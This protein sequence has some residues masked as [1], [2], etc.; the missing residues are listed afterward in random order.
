MLLSR[1]TAK[2]AAHLRSA[3]DL[4]DPRLIAAVAVAGQQTAGLAVTASAAAAN[5]GSRKPNARRGK[6]GGPRNNISEQQK[7]HGKSQPVNK[8]SRLAASFK[9]RRCPPQCCR[10]R[11]RCRATVKP[12]RPPCLQRRVL[13][14][15]VAGAEHYLR[16][17][18]QAGGEPLVRATLKVVA[19]C[20]V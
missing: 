5:S 4:V 19:C 20:R 1:C 10:R 6:G 13:A 9:V 3:W 12:V 17:Y 11:C 8:L 14:N 18:V 15:D 16:S 2:V 7:Q